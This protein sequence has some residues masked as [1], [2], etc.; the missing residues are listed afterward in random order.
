MRFSSFVKKTAISVL[1]FMFVMSSVTGCRIQYVEDETTQDDTSVSQ[2]IVEDERIDINMWYSDEAFS[3][4]L[5]YCAA[6]YESANTNVH[7]NLKYVSEADYVDSLAAEAIKPGKVDLYL[8]DNDKLE[9]MKL[10]GIAAEKIGR[11]HV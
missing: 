4:Y 10:A 11:A 8:I 9:Q 7:V 6:Q 5:K 1:G 2:E 3:G